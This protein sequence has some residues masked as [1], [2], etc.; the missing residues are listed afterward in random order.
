VSRI[1]E[2][3][4]KTIADGKWITGNIHFENNL[5]NQ[6]ELLYSNCVYIESKLN[7]DSTIKQ[8]VI[9]ETVGQFTNVIGS[10]NKK[11]YDHNIVSNGEHQGEVYWNYGYNGWMVSVMNDSYSFYDTKLNNTYKVV[12]HKYDSLVHSDFMKV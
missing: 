5:I 10:D 6:H 4:G 9:P 7:S 3:Q 1:I 12:G 2:F 8:L 11:I